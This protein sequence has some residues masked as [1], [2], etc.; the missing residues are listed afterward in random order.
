MSDAPSAQITRHL[1]ALIAIGEEAES[2]FREVKARAQPRVDAVV[3]HVPAPEQSDFFYDPA[4]L[5]IREALHGRPFAYA[6]LTASPIG[7]RLVPDL[8]RP[9]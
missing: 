7:L 5:Q 4:L 8:P 6:L 2:Y 3:S 9:R 1:A